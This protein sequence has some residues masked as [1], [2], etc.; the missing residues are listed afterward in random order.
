MFVAMYGMVQ[1]MPYIT[2]S[3]NAAWTT[4]IFID[5]QCVYGRRGGSDVCGWECGCG[6]ETGVLDSRGTSG[7]WEEEEVED[8]V[9]L[10]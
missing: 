8:V 4:G 6:I 9:T 7:V 10:F 5:D 2:A 1:G 3:R